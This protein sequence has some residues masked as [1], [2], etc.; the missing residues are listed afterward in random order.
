ML[1]L[2]PSL[3]GGW[4]PGIGDPSFMGWFTVFF[5]FVTAIACGRAF[6]I[7]WR[8]QRSRANIRIA[9]IWSGLTL[10]LILLGI[11]KQLDL[12]SWVTQVGREIAL[13]DG[14]YENRKVIQVLFVKTIAISGI[15][16]IA[17]VFWLAHGH[18]R[19]ILLALIGTALLMT[20][21]LIRASSFH[22]VDILIKTTVIGVKMNWLLE[23]G[24]ISI[25]FLSAILDIRKHNH[26]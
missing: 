25:I 19:R 10:L 9:L 15:L 13:R 7:V 17:L 22:K 12:Q 8:S 4:Q 18:L 3:D 1:F 2:A 24:S 5:Y 26:H 16:V 20:F 6:H 14:W 23:L 21:I 11:N